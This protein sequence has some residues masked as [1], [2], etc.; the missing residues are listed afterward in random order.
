[1]ATFEIEGPNGIKQFEED[2]AAT[3]WSDAFFE[4]LPDS[5]WVVA[6]GR[7]LAPGEQVIIRRVS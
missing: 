2:P 3:E 7:V 4:A 5:L 6:E 1:M